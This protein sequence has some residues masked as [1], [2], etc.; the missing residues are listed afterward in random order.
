[1][2]LLKHA[3]SS[4]SSY[5][6]NTSIRSDCWSRTDEVLLSMCSDAA[7]AAGAGD[8]AA[9]GAGDPDK[10]ARG[11]GAEA[12]AAQDPVP[13]DRPFRGEAG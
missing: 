8:R 11:A 3:Q 10:V 7:A 4:L 13:D 6:L 9:A 5:T 12:G 1:M 2:T